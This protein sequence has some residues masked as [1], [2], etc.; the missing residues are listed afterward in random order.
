MMKAAGSSE[1]FETLY[2]LHC[3]HAH[4]DFNIHIKT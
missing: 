1:T 4:E 3:H 2:H